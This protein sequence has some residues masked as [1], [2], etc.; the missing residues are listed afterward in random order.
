MRA[1][2][3][4]PA[5][6]L[7]IPF[8]MADNGETASTSAIYA[9]AEKTDDAARLACYDSA[10]GR[11]KMAEEAGEVTTISRAEVE[12]VRR[13]SFGFSISS[14]PKLAM[15]KFGNDKDKGGDLD[16][17]TEAVARYTSGLNGAIITLENGQV[18]EQ[19]DSKRTGVRRRGTPQTA[20]IKTAAFGSFMMKIDDG[21]LFRVKRLK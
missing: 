14:L 18:W 6:L 5:L 21:P 16:N 1:I 3:A 2:L 20:L 15:P 10:V 13:D 8:A 9:C 17:L 7:I 12:E 4:A 11:L 19:T